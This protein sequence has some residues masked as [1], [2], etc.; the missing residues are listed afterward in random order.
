ML[1]WPSRPEPYRHTRL[2][3]PDNRHPSELLDVSIWNPDLLG[4]GFQDRRSERRLAFALNGN[5][6]L[7][8][9]AQAL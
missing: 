6:Q 1:L 5:L 4:H 7:R 2:E 3:Q 9:A 8:I